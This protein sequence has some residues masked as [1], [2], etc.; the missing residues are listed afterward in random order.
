MRV[1]NLYYKCVG[2]DKEEIKL[3]KMVAKQIKSSRKSFYKQI[4]EISLY[5]RKYFLQFKKMLFVFSFG[6]TINIHLNGSIMLWEK[7]FFVTI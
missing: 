6:I 5:K 1:K 2:A 7:E 3:L 4:R